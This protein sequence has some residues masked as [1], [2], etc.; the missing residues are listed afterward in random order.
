MRKGFLMDKRG[1]IDPGTGGYLVSSMGSYIVG[2]FASIFAVI[3]GFFRHT[4]KRKWLGLS[5]V[6]KYLIIGGVLVIVIL[7]LGPLSYNGMSVNDLP[8]FDSDKVE[9]TL[10][11]QDAYEGYTLIGRNLIDMDGMVVHNFSY[12]YLGV[13]DDN[14]DIYAQQEYEHSIW[15]DF[16]LGKI[17]LEWRCYMG[18]GN[19]DSSRDT[20]DS[21]RYNYRFNKGSSGV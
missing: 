21:S 18:K 5:R 15:G 11:T 2:I 9:V 17:F 1:Y 13:I 19:A 14:G 20:I 4:L 3:A 16:N 12:G 7:I 8:D 6:S 10:Y